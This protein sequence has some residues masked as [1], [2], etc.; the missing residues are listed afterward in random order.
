MTKVERQSENY[1][2]QPWPRRVTRNRY[3]GKLLPGS[4]KGVNWRP[5]G[6]MAVAQSEGFF[7]PLM[8]PY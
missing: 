6:V 7:V 3:L 5:A 8:T 4:K 1:Y 2:L